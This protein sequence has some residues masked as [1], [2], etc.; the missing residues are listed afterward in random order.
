VRCAGGVE[1]AIAARVPLFSPDTDL[2][3]SLIYAGRLEVYIDGYNEVSPK[4][5]DEIASFA[6]AS[7]NGRILITSQI[8]IRGVSR[9]KTLELLPLRRDEIREFLIGREPVLPQDCPIRAEAYQKL[10]MLYLEDLWKNLKIDSETEAIEQILSNPMDLTTAAIVLGNGKE[11]SLLALQEQ[12]FD[13]LKERHVKKYQA[14]FRTPAFSEDVFKNRVANQD[15]LGQS[16][17]KPEVA[18]LVADKMAIVRAVEVPG[19]PATQEILFRHDRIRDYFTHFAFLEP[20]QD[21]RRLQ[22][23]NDSRFSGVYEYLAKVLDLGL[24]ERLKEQLLM[25]AVESQDHRF[26]D[27]FIRQLSWRQQFASSDPAWLVEYDLKAARDAD[28]KFDGL[29]IERSK[30]ERQMLSLKDIMS[31][32]R[33]VTRILTTYDDARLVTL[34]A[35][36]L[37]ELGGSFSPSNQSSVGSDQLIISPSGMSFT[38]AGLGS[39]SSIDP[40]QVELITQRLKDMTRPVLLITNS[41]VSMNPADRP[42]DLLTEACRR[43]LRNGIISWSAS[44]IYTA[45]KEAPPGDKAALWTERES[46]WQET[47]KGEL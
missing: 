30:L 3:H 35:K 14:P 29:Q 6:A 25:S 39:R 42:L 4:T 16:V 43:F 21:V 26:S 18:S 1:K 41:N 10:A 23:A 37:R 22:Y 31:S 32:S 45:Y 40:F 47:R 38:L 24:A 17:F 7:T 19:Q 13:M 46:L 5:Q 15:D 36:C 44:E 28:L 12:Q 2:L 11:P 8:P 34:G 20:S 9:I 33:D 27:S